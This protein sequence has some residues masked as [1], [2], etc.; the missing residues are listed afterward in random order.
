LV[1]LTCTLVQV[2]GFTQISA[3]TSA[4]SASQGECLL[5]TMPLPPGGRVLLTGIHRRDAEQAEIGAEI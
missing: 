5:M 3:P 2:A 1:L 4:C